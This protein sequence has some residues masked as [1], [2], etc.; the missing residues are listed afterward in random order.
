MAGSSWPDLVAGRTAKASEVEAKF[1]WL[2]RD[3]VPMIGGAQTDSVYFLGTSAARW[4]G[5]FTR[6]INPTS[7]AG[8]VAIGTLT[9]D[10][11]A[12]L[13]LA[14]TKALLLPRLSTAQRDALTG[15]D[16][17]LIFNSTTGQYQFYKTSLGTWSNIGGSV[18]RTQAIAETSTVNVNNT[19][20][21]LNV[22]SGGGRLEGIR[23][24]HGAATGTDRMRVYIDGTVV[25]DFSN[26]GTAGSYAIGPA[27]DSIFTPGD[28]TTSN[29]MGGTSTG[30]ELSGKLGWDFATSCA[31]YIWTE[32]TNHTL[33]SRVAHSLLV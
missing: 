29:Y 16:G 11:G 4:A 18:F 21:A 27:G 26:D 28:T 20:A 25:L 15:R 13:D 9:A 6:S 2:E 10:A 7:T 1:D 32:G 12:L 33:T 17:M 14:G 23:L 22:A 30:A 8:G 31:V 24:R 19:T 5:V 3:I